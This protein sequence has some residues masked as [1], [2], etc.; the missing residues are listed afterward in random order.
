MR[1]AEVDQPG[2]AVGREQHVSRLDVAMDHAALVGVEER[3]GDVGRDARRLAWLERTGSRDPGAQRLAVHEL[4]DQRRRLAGRIH[5]VDVHD[6]RMRQ[7]GG[8]ARLGRQA[9]A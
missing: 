3:L 8:G 6:H 2:A 7:A 4:H 5:V 9:L 1:D